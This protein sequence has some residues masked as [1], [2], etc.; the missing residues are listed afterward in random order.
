MLHHYKLV[1]IGI[2]I[3]ANVKMLLKKSEKNKLTKPQK[4]KKEKQPKTNN[5]KPTNKPNCSSYFKFANMHA[6][7][8]GIIFSAKV[9]IFFSEERDLN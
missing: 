7:H 5:Q 4:K 2:S 6:I 8:M 1:C 9:L 3:A